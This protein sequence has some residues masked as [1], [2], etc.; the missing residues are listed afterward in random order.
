[1]APVPKNSLGVNPHGQ[2]SK[3]KTIENSI[4]VINYHP[5]LDWGR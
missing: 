2:I 3:S 4:M 1:M 5:T